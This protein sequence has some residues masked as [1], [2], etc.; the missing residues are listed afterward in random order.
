MLRPG[1]QVALIWNRRD[2][3]EAFVNDYE[4]LLETQAVDYASAD[5][6]KRL[7][8]QHILDFFAPRKPNYASFP[9]PLTLDWDALQGLALSQSYVPLPD[10]PKHDDFFAGLRDLFERYQ[11]DGRLRLTL[12]THVHHGPLSD[13]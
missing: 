6:E 13:D 5:P 9:N 4:R 1:G 3:E 7:R 10:H 8:D 2:S 11:Q 12:N